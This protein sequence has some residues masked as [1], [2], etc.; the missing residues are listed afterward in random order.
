MSKIILY[1]LLSAIFI[2]STFSQEVP[3]N[4]KEFLKKEIEKANSFIQDDEIKQY[5]YQQ[6][7]MSAFAFYRATAHLYYKDLSTGTINI[8]SEWKNEANIS[9]WLNGDFHLQNIGFLD[10]QTAIFFDLNDFDESYIGP[11][12]WDT[13]R[14]IVSLFLIQ[15]QVSFDFS[16]EEMQEACSLFLKEYQDTLSLVEGNGKEKYT[17]LNKE[18]ISGFILDTFKSLVK[19]KSNAKLLKKWTLTTQNQRFFDFSN[20]DLKKMEAGETYEI[21]GAFSTYLK[22]I[23]NFYGKNPDYFRIKDMASRLYSGL[24]SLGVK[25]YYALIEGPSSELDDDV[26]LEIKESRSSNILQATQ[27]SITFKYNAQRIKAAYQNMRTRIDP[28]VGVLTS[29]KKSYFITKISP[30]KDGYEPADFKSKGNLFSFLQHSAQAL[31][32]AH[33]R[34]DE[35]KPSSNIPYSFEFQ[36]VNAI[37][38]WPSAKTT[39]IELAQKYAKQVII[40]F[41]LFKEILVE[42]D[43]K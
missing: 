10:N 25:K 17:E 41:E 2:S 19:N 22:D 24:G 38:K 3:R 33:S 37:K 20:G 21:K 32:Y 4:R 27:E 26:L 23:G 43:L 1:L 7:S 16:D 8:P 15:E 39:M 14:F 13:I 29:M 30:W 6:M 9:T 5:K 40:D 28:H 42:N 11:F 18:N 12:Y 36:A 31:A 34:S 35:D